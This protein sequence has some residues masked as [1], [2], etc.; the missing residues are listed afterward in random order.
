MH[1]QD[2]FSFLAFLCTFIGI[3]MA[4][5]SP[6]PEAV[7]LRRAIP[8]PHDMWARSDVADAHAAV[9]TAPPGVVDEDHPVT[10][11][12]AITFERIAATDQQSRCDTGNNNYENLTGTRGEG[13]GWVRECQFISGWLRNAGN[14]GRFNIPGAKWDKTGRDY[15]VLI[16]TDLCAFGAFRTDFEPEDLK[17]GGV[18]VA[19][20]IDNS[21]KYFSTPNLS[22]PRVE[23]DGFTY[24]ETDVPFGWGLY[25][26]YA[27]QQM[28]YDVD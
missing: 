19:D 9:Q 25:N 17:V 28:Q 18:D 5:E 6:Q 27:D 22:P 13:D 15:L 23:A 1:I 8:D 20:L 4:N 24:C 12:P 11:N 3:T 21:V 7:E 2:A 10:V 26:M 16:S 14:Y